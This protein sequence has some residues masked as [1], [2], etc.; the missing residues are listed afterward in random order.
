[1]KTLVTMGRG[2]TGKTSFVGLM[3]KYFIELEKT[4]L[5]L[6]DADPD[7]NLGEVVGADLKE[8]GKKTIA[9]LLVETFLE[10]G[11]TTVGVPPTERIE[12]RIWSEG[13]FEGDYFDFIA[14][15]V[16]WVEGCYCMPNAALKGA[17]QS[18]AKNYRYVLIDS[19]AGLE[20]L[21]R[22]ITS[23]VDDI[24]DVIDPSKKSFDHV[25]RAYRIAREVKIDFENFYVVGGFRFPESLENQAR[26]ALKVEFLGKIACDEAVQEYVLAGKSLLDL[27]CDTPA[28][29]SV[30]KIMEKAGYAE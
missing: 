11:G 12:S 15:G 18:F 10:G 28:Y 22:R 6:V 30:K 19:P 13:L 21:N 9:E 8:K 3:T 29:V 17:L 2:G 24:L 4:P 7:L 14:L 27:P 1:M 16:K 23:K 5:L 20:H 26:K 25:E